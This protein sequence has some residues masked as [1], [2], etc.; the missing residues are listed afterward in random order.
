MY[1][2]QYH[3]LDGHRQ[4]YHLYSHFQPH[5]QECYYPNSQLEYYSERYQYHL[6]LLIYFRHITPGFQ[7]YLRVCSLY[8]HLPYLHLQKHTQLRHHQHYQL[9]KCRFHYHQIVY[10]HQWHHQVC[11]CQPHRLERPLHHHHK[12]SHFQHRR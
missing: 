7:R 2:H 12:A 6:L 9:H 5:H 11:H 1:L 8:M 4:N 3:H 10:L